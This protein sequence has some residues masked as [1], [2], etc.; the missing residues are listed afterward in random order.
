M[1]QGFFRFRRRLHQ[2][3]LDH[4]ALWF[5]EYDP[6]RFSWVACPET[7]PCVCAMLRRGKSEVLLGIFNFGPEDVENLLLTVPGYR[8]AEPLLDSSWADFGGEKVRQRSAAAGEN[9]A[10]HL[11]LS[12]YSGQLYRLI[13]I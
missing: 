1:H 8:T 5:G 12:P 11:S 6:S 2:L 9:G 10:F 3:Y 13:N 4:E 7:L